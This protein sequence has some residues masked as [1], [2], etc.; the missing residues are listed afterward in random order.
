V[1]INVSEAEKKDF[2][3]EAYLRVIGIPELIGA[4]QLADQAVKD[5]EKRWGNELKDKES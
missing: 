4:Y 3:K 5:L 2:W 1:K